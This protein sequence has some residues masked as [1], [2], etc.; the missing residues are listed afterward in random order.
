M[1]FLSHRIDIGD[2]SQWEIQ[3]KVD[4][5]NSSMVNFSNIHVQNHF[6][7]TTF[8]VI[9][10]FIEVIVS[11]THKMLESVR[12]SLFKNF[13]GLSDSKFSLSLPDSNTPFLS[14]SG[15]HQL[16]YFPILSYEFGFSFCD[17]G[18]TSNLLICP[19]VPSSAYFR[20]N[21]ITTFT[22]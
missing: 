2:S 18:S 7:H 22:T 20:P 16:E 3:H 17:N 15:K 13:R 5:G 4:N 11:R 21:H 9:V 10:M 14:L 8:N 19:S 6:I 1:R 12:N